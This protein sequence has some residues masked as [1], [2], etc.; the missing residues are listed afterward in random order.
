[1]TLNVRDP[2]KIMSTAA[3]AMTRLSGSLC[4]FT[5]TFQDSHLLLETL[6]INPFRHFYCNVWL[7]GLWFTQHKVHKLNFL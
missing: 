6:P 3:R 1:V 7:W 4:C 2:N 5:L